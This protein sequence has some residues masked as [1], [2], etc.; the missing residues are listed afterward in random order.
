M[1]GTASENA[2]YARGE[3][4]LK[5]LEHIRE[6]GLPDT[7]TS[8]TLERIGVGE[9]N[10]Y[11]TMQALKFL[12]IISGDAREGNPTEVCTRLHRAT[13][14]DYPNVL[15][16]VIRDAYKPI[17]D[18]VDPAQAED[19]RIEDAFRYY[20]PAG[21]RKRMLTLF[22]RLA[23]AAGIIPE[24]KA[25]ERQPTQLRTLG[26]ITRSNGGKPKQ[27]PSKRQ[28]ANK[29][30]QAQNQLNSQGEQTQQLFPNM[31]E[32]QPPKK[33]EE[34]AADPHTDPTVIYRS[35][36]QLATQQLT[37]MILAL[38]PDRKWTKAKRDR[39]LRAV[40]STITDNLD[41][42]VE[43]ID[44]PHNKMEASDA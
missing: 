40:I 27:G 6:R 34:G 3:P 30:Q 4:V 29:A 35:F 2:P 32:E 24:E 16:E 18:V 10:A 22:M 7:V 39:W 36:R 26:Q 19:K 28:E 5:T 21:Q 12:G 17:F 33:P 14:E 37:D 13:T 41:W 23:G 11:Q 1:V 31:V 25:R 15:A 20:G 42:N 44:I 43:V 8:A 38:P 9:S